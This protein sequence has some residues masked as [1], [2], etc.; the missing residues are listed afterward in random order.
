M[1]RQD[2][3]PWDIPDLMEPEA[4]DVSKQADPGRSKG[5]SRAAVGPAFDDEDLFASGAGALELELGTDPPV[6]RAPAAIEPDLNDPPAVVAGGSSALHPAAPDPPEPAVPPPETTTEQTPKAEAPLQWSG[7]E[8]RTDARLRSL[9]VRCFPAL[10][11]LGGRVGLTGLLVGSLLVVASLL[12][13]V[14]SCSYLAMTGQRVSTG[15]LSGLLLL[16]GL[17]LMARSL[18]RGPRD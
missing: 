5:T 8:A 12:A 11:R 1:A 18:T 4:P 17:A 10:G 6:P 16:M 2:T 13:S 14:A 7:L 15:L 3:P 9:A